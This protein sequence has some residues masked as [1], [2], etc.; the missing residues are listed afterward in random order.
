[1]VAMAGSMLC[2]HKVTNIASKQSIITEGEVIDG[3]LSSYIAV[4]NHITSSNSLLE[5]RAEKPNSVHLIRPLPGR[6]KR[7]Y[8]KFAYH[9]RENFVVNIPPKTPPSPENIQE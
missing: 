7:S 8:Q 3:Q 6:E 1:L 4:D 2:D 5:S 9:S